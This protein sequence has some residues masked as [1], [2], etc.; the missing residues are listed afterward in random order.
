MQKIID[1]ELYGGKRALLEH[2]RARAF[3]AIGAYGDTR[4]IDWASVERLVFV[5]KGNICRSPYASARARS[6]GLRAVSFGLTAVEGA[7]ADPAASRNALFRGLDLSTH[8]STSMDRLSVATGDLVVVFEPAHLTLVRRICTGRISPTL[9]GVWAQPI[10][11]YIH[12]PYGRGDRYFQQCFALIDTNI[13]Q[14]AVHM[15]RHHHRLE[16]GAVSSSSAIVNDNSCN[17]PSA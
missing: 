9:L 4:D 2:A 14:L 17:R 6:L 8:R 12:D 15:S 16:L 11:P 5:C 7:L 3:Y 1:I 10:R 13:T